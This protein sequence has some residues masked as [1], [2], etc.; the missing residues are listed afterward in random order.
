MY[1]VWF[2]KW[3]SHLVHRGSL[4]ESK[5]LFL[6]RVRAVIRILLHMPKLHPSGEKVTPGR[7]QSFMEIFTFV[8]LCKSFTQQLHWSP[9]CVDR[10]RCIIT[11][12]PQ[13]TIKNGLFLARFPPHIIH[14]NTALRANYSTTHTSLRRKRQVREKYVKNTMR[15]TFLQPGAELGLQIEKHIM[16]ACVICHL[17]CF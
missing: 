17:F 14:V 5:I 11:G 1:C 16:C 10:W 15:Q 3:W 13:F 7:S 8:L 9:A 4:H 6:Q 12:E 2:N